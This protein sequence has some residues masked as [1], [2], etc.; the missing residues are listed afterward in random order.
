MKLC[1]HINAD[2]GFQFN[3]DAVIPDCD[4]LDPASHQRFIKFGKEGDLLRYVILQVIDSLYLFVPCCGI[5]GCFLTEFSE[6]EDFIRYFVVVF[7]A[8]GFLD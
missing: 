7:F 5:D 1:I 2:A 4:L 3:C 8:V 6:P